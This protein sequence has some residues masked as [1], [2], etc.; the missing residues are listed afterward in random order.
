[1]PWD[2]SLNNDLKEKVDQ[3]VQAT[4]DLPE[5][6]P[7]KF[8]LSTPS[9]GSEAFKR[10]LA[11]TPS[12][13]RIVQD[14][15]QVVVSMKKVMAAKG[16]HVPGIGNR[17]GKRRIVALDKNKSNNPTGKRKRGQ[18]DYGND[19]LLHDDAVQATRVKVEKSLLMLESK[20]ELVSSSNKIPAS[21]ILEAELPGKVFAKQG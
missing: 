14:V 5:D 7:R 11:N 15:F 8:S 6:D 18:F 12:S 10:V 2:T 16:A 21:N 4:S 17:T 19:H 1:M 20:E 9:R 3:H 13:K